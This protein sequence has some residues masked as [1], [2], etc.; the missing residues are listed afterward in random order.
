MKIN[1]VVFKNIYIGNIYKIT[2]VD[3][4]NFHVVLKKS[5]IE[6]YKENILLLQLC[7]HAFVDIEIIKNYFKYLTLSNLIKDNDEF[8][9]AN[10]ILSDIYTPLGDI[11]YF[12]S[13]LT[14]V[15]SDVEDLSY[16]DIKKLKKIYKKS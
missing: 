7:T 13:D 12:V 16:K 14:L 8:I 5:K 1:K 6:L 11:E 4:S 2:P 3:D 9:F 15:Q 10:R